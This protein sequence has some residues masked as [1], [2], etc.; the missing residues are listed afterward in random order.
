M[1]I[2][3]SLKPSE[4]CCFIPCELVVWNGETL[5]LVPVVRQDICVA[6]ER[7]R[8]RWKRWWLPRE[9]NGPVYVIAGRGL[10]RK[11]SESVECSQICSSAQFPENGRYS[12]T[13]EASGNVFRGVLLQCNDS[14]VEKVVLYAS[15]SQTPAKRNT[16]VTEAGGLGVLWT[17]KKICPYLYGHRFPW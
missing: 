3:V 16:A 1:W 5:P 4:R 12:P 13:R 15:A 10:R 6:Q 7:L 17:V 8:I 11:V 2:R 14:S 9:R